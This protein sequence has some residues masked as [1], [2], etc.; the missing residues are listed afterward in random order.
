VVNVQNSFLAKVDGSSIT[1]DSGGR[2]GCV[3]GRRPG[4]GSSTTGSDEGR[5]REREHVS[6][7]VL[8]RRARRGSPP[9]SDRDR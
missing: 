7:R 5:V 8:A 6:D 4:G 1:S 2:S 9:S 3:I